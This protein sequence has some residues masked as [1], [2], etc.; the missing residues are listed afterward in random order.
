MKEKD[1]QVTKSAQKAKTAPKTKKAKKGDSKAEDAFAAI[2]MALYQEGYDIHD[3]ESMK[4][5]IKQ[6]RHSVWNI[7]TQMMRQNPK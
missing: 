4:L 5:T 1:K 2:F 3:I 6:N 7:K